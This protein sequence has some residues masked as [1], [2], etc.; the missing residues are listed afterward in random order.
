M[1]AWDCG[2]LCLEQAPPQQSACFV[3]V[4]LLETPSESHIPPSQSSSWSWPQ[5]SVDHRHFEK[6]RVFS[7][8]LEENLVRKCSRW[9][10]FQNKGI[11]VQRGIKERLSLTYL[12]WFIWELNGISFGK[13]LTCSKFSTNFG[14]LAFFRSFRVL[15]KRCQWHVMFSV[16]I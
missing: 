13:C 7:I 15:S 16:V 12:R 4:V 10:I 2:S 14:P 9:I 8:T 3:T 5:Q 1:A 11:I 6:Y